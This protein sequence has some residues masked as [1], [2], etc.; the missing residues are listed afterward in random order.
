MAHVH[1]YGRARCTLDVLYSDTQDTAPAIQQCYS[2]IIVYRTELTRT[3]LSTLHAEKRESLKSA[4]IHAHSTHAGTFFFPADEVLSPMRCVLHLYDLAA[5]DKLLHGSVVAWQ[6]VLEGLILEH[7]LT[8]YAPALCMWL[9]GGGQ[10]DSGYLDLT[11]FSILPS[12]EFTS[13]S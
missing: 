10:R 13:A 2:T 11:V 6:R 12:R 5:K 8:L 3:S 7:K 9:F 1:C 4:K